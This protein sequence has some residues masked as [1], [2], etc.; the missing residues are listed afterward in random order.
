[1][2]KV[3]YIRDLQGFVEEGYFFCCYNY[4]IYMILTE[5]IDEKIVVVY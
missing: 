5:V 3:I 1:M 2:L 4:H